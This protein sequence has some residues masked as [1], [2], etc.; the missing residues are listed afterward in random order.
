MSILDGLKCERC[1]R[2]WH[3]PALCWAYQWLDVE[4]IEHIAANVFNRGFME[5]DYVT[6]G[7][8]YALTVW[9]GEGGR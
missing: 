5:W 7:V 2:G 6:H 1:G 8:T 3:P 9:E 4:T